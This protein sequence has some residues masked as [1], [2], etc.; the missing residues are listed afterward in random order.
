MT[1]LSQIKRD[2][3]FSALGQRTG[4]KQSVR[5]GY[6]SKLSRPKNKICRWF[7]RA[8]FELDFCIH[9]A[10]LWESARYK[11]FLRKNG[12]GRKKCRQ[13]AGKTLASYSKISKKQVSG[14][15]LVPVFEKIKLK[16]GGWRMAGAMYTK[17]RLEDGGFHGVSAGYPKKSWDY[18][19]PVSLQHRL[20]HINHIKSDWT[21]SRHLIWILFHFNVK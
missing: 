11:S 4:L 20:L 2:S 9:G 19:A 5:F 3:F 18:G 7:A 17:K 6:G 16:Y 14:G 12:G 1:G 10:D 15:R 13:I 8:N 21:A